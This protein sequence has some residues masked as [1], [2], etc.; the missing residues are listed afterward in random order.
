MNKKIEIIKGDIIEFDVDVIV[1]AAN[2]YL[3]GGSG[4][5]GAIHF[6]A[7]KELDIACQKLNGCMTGEAKITPGFNLKAKYIIHTVAPK[8]YDTKLE[9]KEELL[10]NCY[11][12]SY[13]VAKENN[14]KTIA[15][16][17][18]GAGVYMVP[19]DISAK[20]TINEAL[21]NIDFFDKIILVCF[22]DDDYK[23]YNEYFNNLK[24]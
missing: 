6:K 13:K 22:K 4:V 2:N 7:G 21:N 20:I 16:P 15:F 23:C 3:I 14:L 10:R 5:D 1:N 19:I 17:C 18:L 24:F 11:I 8:W 12:N 9:N